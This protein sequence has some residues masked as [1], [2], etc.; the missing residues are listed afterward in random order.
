MD[1]FIDLDKYY[2]NIR[3]KIWKN[4]DLKN[5]IAKMATIRTVATNGASTQLCFWVTHLDRRTYRKAK[6]LFFRFLDIC[7]HQHLSRIWV[8]PEWKWDRN[9]SLLHI[10][11][12]CWDRK[13]WS[14]ADEGNVVVKHG[15]V[16]PGGLDE[17]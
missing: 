2:P 14:M 6:M 13:E 4:N 17:E 3:T 7:F 1:N 8:G 9:Y 12:M 5:V 11:H 15:L 16:D 10:I